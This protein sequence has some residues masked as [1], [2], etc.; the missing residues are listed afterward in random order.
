MAAPAAA[1]GAPT[2]QSHEKRRASEVC[3]CATGCAGDCRGQAKRPRTVVED[4][5]EKM[6]D[7]VGALETAT[8][9]MRLCPPPGP[10]EA[11]EALFRESRA[12]FVGIQ[13]AW[14]PSHMWRYDASVFTN[15][16]ADPM[17]A[18]AEQWI[19]SFSLSA[20]GGMAVRRTGSSSGFAA[21]AAQL[22]AVRS[23]IKIESKSRSPQPSVDRKDLE[24][25]SS[26]IAAEVARLCEPGTPNCAPCDALGAARSGSGRRFEVDSTWSID[27]RRRIADGRAF[28]TWRELWWASIRYAAAHELRTGWDEAQIATLAALAVAQSIV[29]RAWAADDARGV[30]AA[31]CHPLTAAVASVIAMCEDMHTDASDWER[32]AL[33]HF[34]ALLTTSRHVYHGVPWHGFALRRPFSAT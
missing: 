4:E 19:V 8:S 2:V 10:V 32:R 17:S 29:N 34:V 30:R 24:W 12:F 18:V 13:I 25:Y 23:A 33:T 22:N 5:E 20:A 27:Y 15:L 7:L 9:G 14:S 21:I 6:P 3:E 28:R 26:L 16:F 31:R 11:K 1:A